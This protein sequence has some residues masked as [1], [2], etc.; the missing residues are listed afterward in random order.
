MQIGTMTVEE[1]VKAVGEIVKESSNPV[2]YQKQFNDMIQGRN[3][4]IQEYVIALRACAIDCGFVCPFDETHD[5]TDYHIRNRL[6]TGIHDDTLQQE[7]LQKHESL[8][9]VQTGE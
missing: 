4:P 5:L 9:T 8:D 3:M 7:V 2:V 1:A 6:L